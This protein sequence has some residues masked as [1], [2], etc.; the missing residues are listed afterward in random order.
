[1]SRRGWQLNGEFRYLTPVGEGRLA[2]EYLE[3]VIVMMNI[4]VIIV[5]VICSIGT[6]IPLFLKTGSNT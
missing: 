5:S 3:D 1:M 4:P 6:I 2:G